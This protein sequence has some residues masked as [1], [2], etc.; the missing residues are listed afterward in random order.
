MIEAALT[1]P[2]ATVALRALAT[3]ALSD[4]PLA[5][6][7]RR[8]IETARDAHG[9]TLDVDALDAITPEDTAAAI[10]DAAARH[11]LVQRLVLV[12][13]MDAA[14]SE[15]EVR[16]V[17]AFAAALQIDESGVRH[18]RQLLEGKTRWVAFDMLR[19]SFIKTKMK[20]VWAT[21]GVSGVLGFVKAAASVPDAAV[22]ARFAA[23]GELPEGT[24]GRAIYV[25]FQ[26]NGFAS[27][28]SGAAGAVPAGGL[29]HDLGHVLAGYSTDPDGELQIGAFQAGYLGEDGFLMTLF[30]LMLFHLGA[31]IRPG[32][33]PTV[34]R[35][36]FDRF[37]AAYRRGRAVRVNLLTWDP[38]PHMERPLS[39]LRVE[40]GI[41]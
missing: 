38:W 6:R 36:D 34:G 1:A 5:P 28:G 11:A 39:E 7:E 18:V 30:I 14:V 26:E 29:F 22:A 35:M 15:E 2:Q 40:L 12:C 32:V 19:R 21:D 3:V 25:H 9:L 20:D 27:P 13:L 41:H 33:E 10:E 8:L 4:G 37:H 16:A 23:L 17:E 24:L 31:P